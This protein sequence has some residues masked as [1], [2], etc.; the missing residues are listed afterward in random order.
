MRFCVLIVDQ[1]W[2]SLTGTKSVVL[3]GVTF[4]STWR[5]VSGWI[6]P[7][8]NRGKP[9]TF[10]ISMLLNITRPD[11]GAPVRERHNFPAIESVAPTAGVGARA[12]S[13]CIDKQCL[14]EKCGLIFTCGEPAEIEADLQSLFERT[15]RRGSA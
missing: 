4:S 15:A 1:D 14:D 10:G 9:R 7:K 8:I 5:L 12:Q 13:A 3:N 6:W 2:T 11:S